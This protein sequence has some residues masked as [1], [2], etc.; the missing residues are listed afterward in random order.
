MMNEF[1]ARGRAYLLGHMKENDA[2]QGAGCV[3]VETLYAVW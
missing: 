3:T 2:V 1:A